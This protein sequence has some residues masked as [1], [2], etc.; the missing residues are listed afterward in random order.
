M[1]PEFSLLSFQYVIDR[2]KLELFGTPPQALPYPKVVYMHPA[3]KPL[4]P[5]QLNRFI[6]QTFSKM[7]W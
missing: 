1:S 7:L 4:C 6:A 2:K 5:R 3:N